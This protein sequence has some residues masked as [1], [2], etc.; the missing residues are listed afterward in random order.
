M[1]NIDCETSS[2]RILSSYVKLSFNTPEDA[3]KQMNNVS[4]EEKSS[5]HEA[6]SYIATQYRF[7]IH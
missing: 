4:V 1:N 3:S 7:S 6:V 5:L 2:Q